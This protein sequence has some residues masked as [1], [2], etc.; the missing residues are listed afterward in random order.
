MLEERRGVHSPR[1]RALLGSLDSSPD[2]QRL[3]TTMS[4]LPF[5]HFF[6]SSALRGRRG[7]VD[8]MKYKIIIPSTLVLA[9][10]YA[11]LT[12]ITYKE[13]EKDVPHYP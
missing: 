12:R 9:S 2:T 7:I 1:I 3:L 11:P 10:M 4:F 13:G 6:R 8:D 5:P